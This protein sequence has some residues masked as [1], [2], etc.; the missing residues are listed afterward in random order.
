MSK[1][2]KF[3][4]LALFVIILISFLFIKSHKSNKESDLESNQK[5]SPTTKCFN[6][7]LVD[8]V[9]IID[10]SGRI[11]SA[12]KINIISEVNGISKITQSKFEVGEKFKKNEVLIHIKDEDIDLELKSIKSQFLSLLVQV[13]PDLKMDYPSLGSQFQDYV[14]NF[15]LQSSIASNCTFEEIARHW[16]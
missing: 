12:S 13:L 16:L 3:Q 8:V 2:Q 14:N 4:L 11:S 15:N 1:K 6:A 10:I 5:S 9:P 7:E